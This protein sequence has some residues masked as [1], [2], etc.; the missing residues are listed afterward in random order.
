MAQ[1]WAVCALALAAKDASELASLARTFP[2][3]VREGLLAH[4]TRLYGDT[5][6]LAEAERVLPPSTG[7]T[8]ALASLRWLSQ[9]L[10][11]TQVLFDLADLRGYAYYSGVRFAIYTGGASDA[12]VRGGRYDE[13]GAVLAVT[14]RPWGSAWTCVNWWAWCSHGRCARPSVHPG[15]RPPTC[16]LPLRPCAVAGRPW[17]VC[18]ARPRE[19]SR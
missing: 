6:V 11:S 19:R 5:A 1:R 14:V 10:G 17:C 12:L 4:C 18:I 15:V 9:Q 7:L 16:A 2:A 3:A 13:V 8:E